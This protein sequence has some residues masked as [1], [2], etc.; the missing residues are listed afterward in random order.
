[1]PPKIHLYTSWHK[2]HAV[3]SVHW[4]YQEKCI[5]NVFID[6]SDYFRPNSHGFSTRSNCT[7]DIVNKTI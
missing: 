2:V 7:H 6:I 1:M 4:F 3:H 5:S